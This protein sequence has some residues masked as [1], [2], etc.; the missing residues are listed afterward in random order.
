MTEPTFSEAE[1]ARYNL[2]E[3]LL[4]LP[5]EKRLA[6]NKKYRELQDLI[7]NLDWI[8]FIELYNTDNDFRRGHDALIKHMEW[9]KKENFATRTLH[10]RIKE[11]HR[12]AAMYAREQVQIDA[13]FNNWKITDKQIRGLNE[14]L[15]KND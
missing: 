7:D 14:E 15:D 10:E 9:F 5:E 12:E 8:N 2:Q 3:I 13:I 4:N 11:A 6:I 1:L